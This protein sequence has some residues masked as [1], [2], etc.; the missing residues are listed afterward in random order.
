VRTKGQPGP[1]VPLDR[2]VMLG[3]SSL[4]ILT[5]SKIARWKVCSK[6]ECFPKR[7]RVRVVRN[8]SRLEIHFVDFK[9]HLHRA[10]LSSFKPTGPHPGL[11]Q[12]R[13]LLAS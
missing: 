4:Q 10:Q 8:R 3:R 5:G 2:Q 7:R 11:R 13:K 1:M 9:N 6:R 12:R